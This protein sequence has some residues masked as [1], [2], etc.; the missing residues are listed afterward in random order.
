MSLKAYVIDDDTGLRT[1]YTAALTK[2]GYEVE[3][4]ADGLAGKA[5]VEQQVPAAIVVDLL[6]PN[7]D[8]IG[9]LRELRQLPDA[10]QVV[11]VVAS[12]LDAT[13]DTTRET[14]EVGVA[15]YLSKTEYSPEQIASIVDQLVK[16]AATATVHPE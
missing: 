9:F 12:N 13:S 16:E 1:A 3:S 6:M 4:A 14:G 5:L 15:R 8:G 10:D 7:L 11:V 2:L